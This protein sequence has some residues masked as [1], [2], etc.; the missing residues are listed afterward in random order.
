VQ[1]TGKLAFS[2]R[3]G[4]YRVSSTKGLAFIS[5]VSAAFSFCIGQCEREAPC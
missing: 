1:K 3:G 2:H 4:H 5:R